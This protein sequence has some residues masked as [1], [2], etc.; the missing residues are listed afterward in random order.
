MKFNDHSKLTGTHAFLSASNWRW[1][2]D[3][4]EQLHDRYSRMFAQS[5]GTSLH[6]FARRRIKYGYKLHK[7]NMADIRI[8]LCESGIP[9]NVLAHY[10]M[11]LMLANLSN[12]VNDAI[13]Y[14]MEPEQILY[15]SDNAYGTAD[16]ISFRDNVLRIH[17]LKTGV[18]P[19][20]I[21]QLLVYAALF[22]LEYKYRPGEIKIELAIYQNNE[23]ICHEPTVDEVAHVMDQIKMKDSLIFKFRQE[24]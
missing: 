4:A 21:E 9:E 1:L 10:D 18:T 23:V 20:H 22:C 13:G 2:N 5:I 11:D 19:T 16:A 12:F 14:K 6:E 17:D 7:Y 3:D 24:V 8:H 15:Y